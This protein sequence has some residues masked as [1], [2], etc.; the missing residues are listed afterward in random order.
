MLGHQALEEAGSFCSA[1]CNTQAALGH[2]RSCDNM[3]ARCRMSGDGN[4]WCCHPCGTAGHSML[5]A[6]EMGLQLLC[7]TA[8][9]CYK[10]Y[11]AL[12]GRQCIKALLHCS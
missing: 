3:L 2:K 8:G 9:R 5:T 7:S 6:H 10:A 12:N 4:Q 11:Q 1:V